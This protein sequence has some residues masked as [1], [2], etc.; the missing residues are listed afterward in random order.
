MRSQLIILIVCVTN[1]LSAHI[2]VNKDGKYYWGLIK[3][4][5]NQSKQFNQIDRNFWSPLID[6]SQFIHIT[7]TQWSVFK[8]I[9]TDEWIEFT[10]YGMQF[11]DQENRLFSDLLKLI[12]Q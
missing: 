7:D 3:T 2:A 9:S 12:E 10:K 5:F 11:D 8:D 4:N 1:V 6:L